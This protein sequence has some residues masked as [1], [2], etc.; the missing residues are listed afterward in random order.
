LHPAA[1]NRAP[2]GHEWHGLA[3][4]KPGE[5]G[6]ISE[7]WL[8]EETCKSYLRSV[9]Q[10]GLPGFQVQPVPFMAGMRKRVRRMVDEQAKNSYNEKHDNDYAENAN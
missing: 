7:K 1:G 10:P 5:P 9:E 4:L 3:R 8:K 2:P 6:C